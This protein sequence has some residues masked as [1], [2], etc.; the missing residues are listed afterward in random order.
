MPSQPAFSPGQQSVM[1]HASA[2]SAPSA[3]EHSTTSMHRTRGQETLSVSRLLN[4]D[5][6]SHQ[7][8]RSAA[9]GSHVGGHVG[10]APSASGDSHVRLPASRSVSSDDALGFIPELCPH[11]LTEVEVKDLMSCYFTRLNPIIALVNASSDHQLRIRHRASHRFLLTAICTAAAKFILPHR[12][13]ALLS[14]ARDGVSK[15]TVD[16]VNTSLPNIQALSILA[17]YNEPQDGTAFRH[18][19]LAILLSFELGLHVTA[20]Q[21]S[22]TVGPHIPDLADLQRT[23]MQLACFE[24]PLAVQRNLSPLIDR[25]KMPDPRAWLESLDGFRTEI[26]VRIASAFET[27]GIAIQLAQD[28]KQAAAELPSGSVSSGLRQARLIKAADATATETFSRWLNPLPGTPLPSGVP[29]CL[30]HRLNVQ[31]NHQQVRSKNRIIR[32]YCS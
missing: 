7:A 30:F 31:L 8:L 13:D 32:G 5:A 23:Y 17:F 22:P 28:L 21:L 20:T 29:D 2:D 4:S 10:A 12:Y 27:T 3:G 19:R 24:A 9:L 16:A 18:V 1:S 15:L 14:I 25:S 26:D 11:Y 6:E